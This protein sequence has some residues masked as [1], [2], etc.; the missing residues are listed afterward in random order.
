[1]YRQ[2][3]KNADLIQAISQIS[4]RV[5]LAQDLESFNQLLSQH[6]NLI[7]RQIE[8]PC[9]QEKLFPDYTQGI[10]K[11]LGAWGAILF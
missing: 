10:V 3:P 4:E 6:E 11:S 9:V 8:M 5:A 7:Y 2:K 1:M